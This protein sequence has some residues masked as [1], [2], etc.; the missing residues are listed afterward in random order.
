MNVQNLKVMLQ[1]PGARRRFAGVELL[2]QLMEVN[3]DRL[4]GSRIREED[5][6]GR[7]WNSR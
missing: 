3:A 5:R 4:I 2:R 1:S 7:I 6:P